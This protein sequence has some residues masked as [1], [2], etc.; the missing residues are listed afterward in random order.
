MNVD[1]FTL[2][3]F[4]GFLCRWTEVGGTERPFMDY[5]TALLDDPKVVEVVDDDDDERS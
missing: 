1:P 4:G 5:S 2:V 3:S